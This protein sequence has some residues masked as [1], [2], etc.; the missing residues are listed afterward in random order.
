MR[1]LI[2]GLILSA[3]LLAIGLLFFLP[4]ERATTPPY[5]YVASVRAC[6]VEDAWVLPFTIEAGAGG[7]NAPIQ[8]LALAHLTLATYCRWADS[9]ARTI[10][11][12]SPGYHPRTYTITGST[13]I[14][15]VMHRSIVR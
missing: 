8:S 4:G 12:E 6:D 9:T 2:I 5:Y 14:I 1:K 10:R 11:V 7:T 15:A 13:N 3:A